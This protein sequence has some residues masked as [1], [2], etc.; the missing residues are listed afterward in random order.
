MFQNR[1]LRADTRNYT[2]NLETTRLSLPSLVRN[3]FPSTDFQPISSSNLSSIWLSL[4]LD[5]FHFFFFFFLL[6][7]AP[8]SLSFSSIRRVVHSWL[9][10]SL[11]DE[12][13]KSGVQPG[14]P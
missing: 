1:V 9:I 13:W 14:R 7:R 12:G 8:I 4:V 6:L 2:R 11:K 10:S 5:Y 3:S